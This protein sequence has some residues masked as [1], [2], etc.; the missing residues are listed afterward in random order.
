MKRPPESSANVC[1]AC[2]A[3]M[4]SC[5]YTFRDSGG[6]LD[7]LGPQQ[8]EQSGQVGFPPEELGHP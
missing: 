5:E 6:D 4:A 8:N 2:A 7:P 1:R 3:T